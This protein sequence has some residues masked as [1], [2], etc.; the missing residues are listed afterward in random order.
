[1]SNAMLVAI[2]IIALAAVVIAYFYFNRSKPQGATLTA[3]PAAPVAKKSLTEKWAAITDKFTWLRGI[4]R[5]VTL[6]I[7]SVALIFG[8]MLIG[9]KSSAVEIAKSTFAAITGLLGSGVA[10]LIG[11]YVCRRIMLPKVD[12][13]AELEKANDP[14]LKVWAV[15]AISALIAF[16]FKL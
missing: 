1:M 11:V 16:V 5:G 10:I 3:D 6:A 4:P 15:I 2:G 13:V 7:I 9:G 12:F 8:A 14:K